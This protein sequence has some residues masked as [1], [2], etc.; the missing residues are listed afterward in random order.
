MVRSR[1][2]LSAM[3]TCNFCRERDRPFWTCATFMH[4]RLLC[5]KAKGTGC[6]YTSHQGRRFGGPPAAIMTGNLYA[7]PLSKRP[8]PG[9]RDYLQVAVF[10]AFFLL[11]MLGLHML[12]LANLV[13][14]ISPATLSIYNSLVAWHK[15]VSRHPRMTD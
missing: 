8:P 2:G 5:I 7:V 13:F 4:P 1:G 10:N 6:S 12:Q 9:L 11:G 14:R 15:D 3:A